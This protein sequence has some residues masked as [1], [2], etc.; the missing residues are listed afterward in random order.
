MNSFYLIDK[1]LDISSFDVIRRMRKTLN[2]KKMGHTGTLDPL[3]TGAILIATG[4]Y[5][6][7]IPYFEKDAKVYEFDIMLDGVTDSFDLAEPVQHIS[8][9]L[10][11]DGKRAYDRARAGEDV[12][13]KT[14]EVEIQHI[15]ILHFNY[16]KLTLRA[17]V[18]AGTYIR[19]IAADLG[20]I[21]GSGGYRGN[22]ERYQ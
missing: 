18:S 22:L 14:R 9:A 10:K 13:M 6:K 15:E 19:S 5:T 21:L 20:D 17:Q 16:P 2:I 1:P 12:E 7:L 11:I 8:S 4:N 3:A